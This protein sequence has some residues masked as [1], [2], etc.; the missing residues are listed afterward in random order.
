MAQ[1]A[2][3]GGICHVI[4]MTIPLG[5]HNN[6][7]LFGHV[8]NTSFEGFLTYL[9]VSTVRFLNSYCIHI[10]NTFLCFSIMTRQMLIVTK[11]EMKNFLKWSMD[12]IW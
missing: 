2:W 10:R 9:M 11:R 1:K 8:K 4:V 7:S 12:R 5:I 6:C 3:E